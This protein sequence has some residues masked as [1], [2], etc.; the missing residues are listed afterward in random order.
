MLS[1]DSIFFIVKVL[2]IFILGKLIL[3]QILKVDLWMNSWS[4]IKD[5]AWNYVDSF[6]VILAISFCDVYNFMG[7]VVKIS[8]E[9]S[10][11]TNNLA[12][13]VSHEMQIVRNSYCDTSFE[14]LTIIETH[15]F[16]T[17]DDI[18]L[19]SRSQ[20]FMKSIKDEEQRHCGACN[21]IWTHF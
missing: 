5:G 7:E 6:N 15:D 8:L 19:I 17:F 9:N 21:I 4:S 1:E 10:Q 12:S 3:H 14:E 18:K 16:Y 2:N 13:I 11:N 20:S